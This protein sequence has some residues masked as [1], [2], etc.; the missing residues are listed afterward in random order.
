MTHFQVKM[1]DFTAYF[2]KFGLIHDIYFKTS[3]TDGSIK[4]CLVLMD[5]A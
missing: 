2:A 1:S 4:A 5:S 3:L